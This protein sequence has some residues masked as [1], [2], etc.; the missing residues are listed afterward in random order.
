MNQILSVWHQHCNAVLQEVSFMKTYLKFAITWL[1]IATGIIILTSCSSGNDDFSDLKTIIKNDQEGIFGI[2]LADDA[3]AL[4]VNGTSVQAGYSLLGKT[5]GFGIGQADG[6]ILFGRTKV[7]FRRDINVDPVNDSLAVVLVRYVMRGQF[8][9]IEGDGSSRVKPFEH[10]VNRVITFVRRDNPITDEPWTPVSFSAAYGASTNSKMVLDSI[11]ISTRLGTISTHDPLTLNVTQTNIFRFQRLDSI[12]V[13]IKAR[14]VSLAA[15]SLFGTLLTGRNR[16]RD[17][18]FRIRMLPMGNDHFR[19]TL[20]IGLLQPD[21][22]NQLG[23]DFYTFSTL[24]HPLM[25]Y[26]SFIILVPYR[27]GSP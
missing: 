5:Y 2:E 27:V 18:R 25:P 17:G 21:G 7:M 22:V 3:E 12:S 13:D 26:D 23:I 1:L 19:A 11:T 4:P 16:N 15:D 24:L 10:E 8:V 9:V 6:D 14:N 20:R